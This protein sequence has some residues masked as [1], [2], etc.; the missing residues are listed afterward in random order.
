MTTSPGSRSGTNSSITWSTGGPALIM[1]TI[2]RGERS[3]ATS[4]AAVSAPMIVVPAAGPARNSSVRAA[5]RLCTTTENPWSAMLSARFC[6][7][8]ARPIRPMSPWAGTLL[9]SIREA[10]Y[11]RWGAADGLRQRRQCHVVDP[12]VEEAGQV[13]SRHLTRHRDEVGRAGIAAGEPGCIRRED[14]LHQLVADLH[15]QG[16]ERQAAA[17]GDGSAE[18]LAHRG[19]GDRAVG[20]TDKGVIGVPDGGGH[21]LGAALVLRPEEFGKGGEALVQPD[22]GPHRR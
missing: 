4:S 10:A 3:A 13:A 15:P 12:R 8:T 17:E 19:V 14:L 22:V 6:P 11:R 9:P 16:V 20:D 2:R 21:R 18:Q 7:M 1:R 5:V